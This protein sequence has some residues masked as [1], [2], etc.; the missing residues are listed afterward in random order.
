MENYSQ[1]PTKEN[2]EKIVKSLS[3]LDEVDEEIFLP[4]VVRVTKISKKTL[5]KMIQNYKQ[6]KQKKRKMELKPLSDSVFFHPALDFKRGILWLGFRG[7]FEINDEVVEKNFYVY[8]TLTDE[9]GIIIDKERFKL[10]DTYWIPEG[11]DHRV[12]MNINRKWDLQN[13]LDLINRKVKTKPLSDTYVEIFSLFK[14][15]LELQ[16]EA[17][18]HILAAW[19]IGTYFH[20]I[21]EAFPYLFF[22]G[23]KC[24]GKTKSLL[25]L[26]KLSFNAI[27]SKV[28]FASLADTL[29]NLRGTL[30]VDQ[31]ENLNEF[32]NVDLIGLLADG[33]KRENGKRR[34][35]L[36][37]AN[38]RKVVELETYS[39]KA[40]AS[41][42]ELP[43][44]LK[45]RV[46]ELPMIKTLLPL[47]DLD[48]LDSQKIAQIRASL[49]QNLIVNWAL[50]A[51]IYKRTG[52]D[53]R[54][55][56]RELWRPLEA[57]FKVVELPP[58]LIKKIKMGF[59]KLTGENQAT[60]PD[61]VQL[62]FEAILEMAGD[63]DILKTTA[64][65]ILDKMRE[66]D[67]DLSENIT[68]Q[69]IGKTLHLHKVGE[70][71][72]NRI[73][74]KRFWLVDVK[75][76]QKIYFA[77]CPSNMANMA[78]AEKKGE[79]SGDYNLPCQ[80]HQHGKHGNMASN[81][82]D[83]SSFFNLPC[84]NRGNNCQENFNSAMSHGNFAMLEKQHGRKEDTENPTDF[85]GSAKCAKSLGGYKEKKLNQKG[86]EKNQPRLFVYNLDD[87]V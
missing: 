58:K 78:E 35:V 41:I 22:S 65:D 62:L 56:V 63:D 87:E 60:L 66:L 80:K 23:P 20:T 79:I 19:V 39:P 27:K 26:E 14:E 36:I 21:F 38:Q 45:D 85:N 74:N 34:L 55:R 12:L 37:Q 11:I 70:R 15:F 48:E 61:N 6:E 51:D 33:Y 67:E 10:Y 8:S 64:S 59:L 53:L 3:L 68:T 72:N 32:K 49:Y 84:K 2:L 17:H 71:T 42:R 86:E 9:I 69:W 31:A 82:P 16:D 18:Y 57:I 47:P 1:H 76:I 43:E 75:K 29:D 40:F 44:D 5:K 73:F 54:G 4:Q 81:F 24:S 7:H 83:N 77:Y 28:T 25:L 50:V 30:L 52:T 13:L 46:I